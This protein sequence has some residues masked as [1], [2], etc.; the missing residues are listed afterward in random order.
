MYSTE[1]FMPMHPIKNKLI[2]YINQ[3]EEKELS[4]LYKIITSL[5]EFKL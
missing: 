2:E 3:A 1:S 5:K 4:F